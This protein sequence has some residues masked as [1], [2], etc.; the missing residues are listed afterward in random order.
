MPTNPWDRRPDESEEAFAAFLIYRDMGRSRSLD[1][2]G[3]GT[4]GGQKGDKRTKTGRLARWSAN[5]AWV[6]RAQAWDDYLQSRRQVGIERAV[7]DEA[8]KWERRRQRQIRDDLEL[9]LLFR[10][11]AR[12]LA[13]FPTAMVTSEDGRTVVMPISPRDLKDAASIAKDA[14]ALAWAAIDKA[15]PPDDD[16]FDPE[17]ATPEENRAYVE[18]QARRRNGRA[19]RA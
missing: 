10:R 1:A 15:L 8:E 3:R 6:A 11:R 4:K 18:A 2:V 14:H 13:R 17:N 9:A 16:D 7:T 5:H 19:G 12:E